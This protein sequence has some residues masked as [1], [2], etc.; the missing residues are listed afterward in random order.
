MQPSCAVSSCRI[1]DAL[2]LLLSLWKAGHSLG[3]KHI[4]VASG[5]DS[6][7]ALQPQNSVI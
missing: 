1:R 5:S 7:S 3:R 4:G 2:A 6:H